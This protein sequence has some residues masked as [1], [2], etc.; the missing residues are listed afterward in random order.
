[1]G[2]KFYCSS[3]QR[4]PHFLTLHD[5]VSRAL[6]AGRLIRSGGNM[7]LIEYSALV[8]A[9]WVAFDVLFAIAWA[10]FH[11]VRRRTEDQIKATLSL[12]RRIDDGGRSEVAYF[13]EVTG[14]P[15]GLSFKKTS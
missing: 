7:R 9:G 12:V 3:L 10:R 2:R 6:L 11:S 8:L 15:L 13:D 1:M 14:G 5:L 4:E